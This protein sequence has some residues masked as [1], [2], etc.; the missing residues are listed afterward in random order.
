[1]GDV[2]MGLV[3]ESFF[4]DRK[5]PAMERLGLL[6]SPLGTVEDRQPVQGVGDVGMVG[7]QGLLA[8]RKRA[9]KKRFGLLVTS[10]DVIKASQAG[11]GVGDRG[12]VRPQLLF[13]QLEGLWACP[14]FASPAGSLSGR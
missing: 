5:R 1:M 8:D 14:E 2:G 12:V 10:L 3:S 7:S 4:P 13:P 9:Q 11:E 6:E